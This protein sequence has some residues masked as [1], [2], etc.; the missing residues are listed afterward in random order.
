[1]P[2]WILC[3][4]DRVGDVIIATAC[5][6]PIRRQRP[7]ARLVFVARETM[8]PLLEGHPLLD[9]FI[10]LP[11]A[12]RALTA[13]FR[14]IGADAIVC[15]HP[16]RPVELAGW[17]AG[18]PRRIGWRHSL[19]DRLTLTHRLRDRR[20]QGE[21]HEGEYNFDLLA[22]LGIAPPSGA[23]HPHVSLPEASRDTLAAKLALA[24]GEPYCVLNPTAFSPVLRWPP[25]AFAQLARESAGRLGRVVL[26][27][28]SADDP[29]VVHLR[30]RLPK[31]SID[32]TG[33]LNLGELGWLLKSARVLISRNTGSAHLAA[34]VRCPLVELFGRSEPIY[35][36]TRWRALGEHTR[37][38][39]GDPGRR[40]W[41]EP[42]R[43]HWGRGYEAIPVAEVLAAALALTDG[44]R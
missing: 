27:A 28:E 3:R 23:L 24:D 30:A 15:L 22:P 14:E 10:A 6:E 40:R 21:K 13:A 36:P 16:D 39:V 37:V 4:P 25:E 32:L 42:K 1:M 18:I 26:V 2:T 8:R 19:L 11:A 7:D 17:R 34:A 31:G 29:A 5:L 38:I 20:R 9:G 12:P 44:S 43:A 41:R 33:R 35:G